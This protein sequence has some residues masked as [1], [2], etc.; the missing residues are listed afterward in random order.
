MRNKLV[1][2]AA[3]AVAMCVAG[4]SHAQD[5]RTALG[6]RLGSSTGI[7]IKHFTKRG[8]ALEGLLTTRWDGGM[9]TGLYEVVG[10]A[11]DEP[12]LSWY[13]GGG[14]HIGFWD[15]HPYWLDRG[16]TRSV[17]GVDLILGLEYT[18]DEIPLNLGFDW[19]PAINLVGHQGFWADEF[20]LSVRFAFK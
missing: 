3:M 16:E 7:T 2:L 4:V 14:A 1:F 20:A 12:N 13:F 11:F 9:I 17:L 10:N 8:A 5:Y 6:L 15:S 19:K 18:F